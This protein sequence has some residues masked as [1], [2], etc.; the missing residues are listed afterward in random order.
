MIVVV[1]IFSFLS[2]LCHS[3]KQSKS[4]P[5]E[6][7]T[8]WDVRIWLL[9]SPDL[10]NPDSALLKVFFSIMYIMESPHVY[11]N[12]RIFGFLHINVPKSKKP[13]QTTSQ[14]K[15]YDQALLNDGN[16]RCEEP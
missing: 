3:Y 7:L 16:E 9:W 5:S 15:L 4:T 6:D 10:K 1:V 8:I 11:K 12:N 14:Y 2:I 13:T